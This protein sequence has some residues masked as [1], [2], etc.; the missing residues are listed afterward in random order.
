MLLFLDYL[1]LTIIWLIIFSMCMHIGNRILNNN[2]VILWILWHI[3]N[4]LV[5][6]LDVCKDDYI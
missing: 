2:Q 3:S 5:A 4:D 6:A 1:P